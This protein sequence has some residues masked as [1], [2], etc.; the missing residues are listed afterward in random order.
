LGDI[1]GFVVAWRCHW[2]HRSL[3]TSLVSLQ[4]EDVIGVVVAW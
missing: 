3:K 1:V 4:L 2:C